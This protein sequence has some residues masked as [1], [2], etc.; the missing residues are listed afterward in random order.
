MTIKREHSHQTVIVLVDEKATDR[1]FVKEW[2]KKSRFS[3]NEATD[4][5]QVMEEISDFTVRSRPDVVLLEVSSLATYFHIVKE[6]VQAPFDSCR[7][8]IF[9]LSNTGNVV[10]H[11]ECFE[12]NLTQVEAKL[13]KMIPKLTYVASA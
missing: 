6:M 1:C 2:F 8:L 13:N 4:I 7:L 5:F 12:G 10:N 11:R 9:A 3:T